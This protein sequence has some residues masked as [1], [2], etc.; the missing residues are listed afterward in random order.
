MLV[1]CVLVALLHIALCHVELLPMHNCALLTYESSK[2]DIE[3]S[4]LILETIYTVSIERIA[5][6]YQSNQVSELLW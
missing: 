1:P 5:L 2:C 3:M 6:D 4:A